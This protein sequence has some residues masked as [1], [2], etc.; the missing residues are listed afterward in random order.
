MKILVGPI[1]LPGQIAVDAHNPNNPGIGGSEYHSIVLATILAQEYDVTLWLQ[2]GSLETAGLRIVTEL[3]KDEDFGLQISS[4]S[5]ANE[6]IPKA[7]PLVAI[8]HH[9]FDTHILKLPPRT[10]AIANVGDYQLKSNSRLARRVGIGQIWLPVFLRRP[11][12]NAIDRSNA[13]SFTV[14]HVSSMHPSKGF[15]DVLSAWMDYLALGGKGAL[16]VLGGQSLYGIKESHPYLPVS[17]PYGEKLLGIMGGRVHDSVKFLGR[18]PGDIESRIRSWDLAVLNPKGFGESE[19]VSM[20]DCWREAV[21][22]VAGN[23]FGQRDYM[24]LF[25]GLAS[26]SPRAIAKIIKDLSENPVKLESLQTQALHEY[27]VLFERGV[28]SGELWRQLAHKVSEGAPLLDAGLPTTK[29]SPTLRL[30]IR[31]EGFQIK[32]QN[33]ASRVFS[34]LRPRKL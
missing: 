14:G 5:A 18:V 19:S 6:P 30:Q 29:A 28:H 25:P 24:R 16:E 2:S 32:L 31:I 4:S 3:S 9:P 34:L 33:L 23:R 12:T 13:T 21:P 10:L 7:Y 20:K 8:S 22:V 1:N 15:H 27:Q 26:S 11:Q 17:K